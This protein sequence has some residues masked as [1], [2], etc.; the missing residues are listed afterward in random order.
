MIRGYF[1]MCRIWK[2]CQNTHNFFFYQLTVD[3]NFPPSGSRAVGF[4]LCR[5]PLWCI[6]RVVLIL[7]LLITPSTV[8]ATKKKNNPLPKPNLRDD[9]PKFRAEI[10]VFWKAGNFSPV[11]APSINEKFNCKKRR[12]RHNCPPKQ[13]QENCHSFVRAQP[14]RRARHCGSSAGKYLHVSPRNH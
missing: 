5:A 2:W 8:S 9:N 11:S 6:R 10:S 1:C 14:P 12:I 13:K 4:S 3:T 7:K